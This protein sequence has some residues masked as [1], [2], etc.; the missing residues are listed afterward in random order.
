M[1]FSLLQH[2]LLHPP[3]FLLMIFTVLVRLTAFAVFVGFLSITQCPDESRYRSSFRTWPP[4][5]STFD[6]VVV[7][8]G[9]AGITI[10]S[11]LA[12][13]GFTVA[14]LEAGDYYEIT[15][16]AS[17]VPGAAAIGIGADVKTATNV[18]WKFVAEDVPGAGG[19]NIH[20][21]RGKC[22]G[23]SYVWPVQLR[24]SGLLTVPLKFGLE[25]HDLPS[26]S[27]PP[28]FNPGF[29]LTVSTVPL[30]V[31]WTNGQRLSTTPVTHSTT[32]SLSTRRQQDLPIRTLS[33][34]M[35]TP[36]TTSLLSHQSGRRCTSL[37]PDMRCPFPNG[38]RK[39]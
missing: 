11:R 10:G 24:S 30:G 16:A 19:R 5:D 27:S 13:K 7:G 1:T 26:V 9:T 22:V 28:P 17:R 33:Q 8:G 36:L 14:V 20:Y 38:S 34:G 32:S 4:W 39:G 29:R 35:P 18:D 37:S 31:P 21:A 12:Q 23:G 2:F 3:Y 6:Y 15:H 25:L